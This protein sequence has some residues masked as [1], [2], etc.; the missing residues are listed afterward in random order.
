MHRDRRHSC[1]SNG[2][3]GQGWGCTVSSRWGLVES[4]ILCS[5]G[6]GSLSILYGEFNVREQVY[7]TGHNIVGKCEVL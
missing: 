5:Q 4:V 1:T 6:G 7:E 2:G 3:N